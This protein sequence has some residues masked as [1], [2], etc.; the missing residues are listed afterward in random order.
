[1]QIEFDPAKDAINQ[2]RHG[3]TLAEAGELDWETLV[4]KPDTRRDYGETRQIGYAVRGARLYCVV[5]V[6]RGEVRRIISLRKA[7]SREVKSYA[8][9]H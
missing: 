1:M 6:D 5:Y 3:L 4:A 8:Q 9:D 2:A 7:N